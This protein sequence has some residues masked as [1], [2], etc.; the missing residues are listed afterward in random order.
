MNRAASRSFPL[1]IR[2]LFQRKIEPSEVVPH[3][4]T[5]E[6]QQ[7]DAHEREQLDGLVVTME[8]TLISIIQGVALYFLIDSAKTSLVQMKLEVWPYIVV[9]LLTILLFWSRSLIHTFTVIRWPLEF[10]HNFL[11]IIC[12][13]VEAVMFTQLVNPFHW[14]LFGAV[15][16]G[17]V[18]GLFAFDLRMIRRRRMESIGTEREMLCRQL[19][20]D[21]LLNLWIIMPALVVF[22]ILAAFA[23]H[24]WPDLFI[25]RSW[26]VILGSAQILGGLAY[27]FSV[28]NFFTRITPL[29]LRAREQ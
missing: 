16:G 12:T 20:R 8:L 18:W 14:Y 9:G 28:L 29:I 21:Q 7:A 11:Y 5:L 4:D 1:R 22:H 2:A 26:H 15:Y 25:G 23:I 19:E 27:L 3:T 17:L 13:F 10:G 24:F 6:Q